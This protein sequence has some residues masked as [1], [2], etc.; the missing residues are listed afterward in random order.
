MLL[1]EPQRTQGDLNFAILGFPVRVHPFFWLIAVLLGRPMQSRLQEMLIWVTV[2]FVSILV[3]EL[4]H[5]MVMRWY[6]FR[7]WI[8]LYGMG[9]LASYDQGQAHGSAGL[10]PRGQILI[11]AAG[12][13][14]GFFLAGLI[15]GM[16]Y[17]SGSLRGFVRDEIFGFWPE[18]SVQSKYLAFF[19]RQMIWVNVGWGLINLL[20]VYPLDGGHICREILSLRNPRAGI[21]RSLVV[22]VGVGAMMAVYALVGMKQIWVAVMFGFLAY[23]S[24]TTLQA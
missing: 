12:P 3:H 19:L 15:L 7:P 1:G 4:G 2:V 22:S 24:Y 13:A 10:Q 21:E 11:S 20:P 8:T 17:L 5:A 14:A 18:I 16:A 6:G 9:G 23:S